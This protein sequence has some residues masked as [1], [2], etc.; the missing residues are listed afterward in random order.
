MTD[1]PRHA[2]P[3][4]AAAQAQKHVTHNAALLILDALDNASV[5]D[6]DLATPPGSPAEGDTYLIAAAP[7]GAWTGQVGKIGFYAGAAW[8]FY[9]AFKGLMLYV[10]DEAVFIVY[11]GAAWV[12]LSTL[13]GALQNLALLGINTTAD[14]TNKL[15]V[16]SLA[17]LFD[18]IGNGTQ[19]KLNKAAAGDS[20]SFLFQTGYSGRAEIG[21]TGDDNFHFKVSANGSTFKD[22]ITIDKTTGAVRQLSWGHRLSIAAAMP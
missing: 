19:V 1:T 12:L 5:I 21:T 10:A 14:A 11:N 13:I 16:K 15:A 17:I 8:N 7:T 2:M 4:I 9:P 18:N 3:E 22:A 6:R 20:A